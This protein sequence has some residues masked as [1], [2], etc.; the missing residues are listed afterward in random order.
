MST[1]FYSAVPEVAINMD[2]F[3]VYRRAANPQKAVQM[4]SYMRNL[5]PFLGIQTPQRR[6]LNRPFFKTIDKSTA[7]WQFVFDCWQLAEREFQYLAIDYLKKMQAQLTAADLSN[8]KELVVT[9]SWWDTIDALD[10]IIGDVA[11]RYPEINKTLLGWSLDENIWLR[12][13]AIDHQLIRKE[14]TDT[15]LLEQIIVNNL[16]HSEFFINKAIGWS[17]RNYSK[18]NPGWV[19]AFVEKYR[20]QMAPLS[21][22]EASKYL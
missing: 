7:N 5:F 13:T 9:K 1:L 14:K 15:A 19:R 10:V 2:I 3:N 16:G 22:K 6:E 11:L 12:R 4:A 8:L 21:I 20:E 17:L 18:T